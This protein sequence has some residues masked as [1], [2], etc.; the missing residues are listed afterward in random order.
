MRAR[1]SAPTSIAEFI[2]FLEFAQRKGGSSYLVALIG[3]RVALTGRR[4][5]EILR[6]PKTAMTNDGINLKDNKTKAGEA[7]RFYLVQWS[8]TLRQVILEAMNIKHRRAK[9]RPPLV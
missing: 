9:N 1:V 5:G 4:R 7:E 6:L 3:C 8:P 2:T